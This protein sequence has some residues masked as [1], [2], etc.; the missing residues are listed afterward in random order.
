M[1][2][3]DTRLHP[4]SGADPVDDDL[5]RLVA[6]RGWVVRGARDEDGDDLAALV[7]GVFAEYP[8]C[9]LDPEGL[10]ADLFRW[11]TELAA[12]DGDGWVVRADGRLVACVGVAPT[13]PPPALATAPAVAELKRLYVHADARRRGL[14]RALV[15]RVEGWA[16]DRSI[17]GVV[18]WSD[19]RFRDAHRLY[20]A[21]GYRDTGRRRDLHDPSDTTEAEFV[22]SL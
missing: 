9:V 14:G 17:G 19:T 1:L 3:A 5:A 16:R 7:G 18:L 21:C 6:A 8:G 13:Q 4:T 15:G 12:A 10:D 2:A 22:R 20:T 11:R